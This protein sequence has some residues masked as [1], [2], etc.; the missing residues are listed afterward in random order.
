MP[1]ASTT[2]RAASVYDY[3]IFLGLTALSLGRKKVIL[4]NAKE[5]DPK[6]SSARFEKRSKRSLPGQAGELTVASQGSRLG[7]RLCAVQLF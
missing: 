6:N 1:S 7:Q 2:L 5:H 4:R 3:V